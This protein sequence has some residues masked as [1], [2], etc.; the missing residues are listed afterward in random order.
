M[1]ELSR[2][3]GDVNGS[4]IYSALADSL[5]AK[6][7]AVYLSQNHSSAPSGRNATTCDES[8][9]LKKGGLSHSPFHSTTATT[10]AMRPSLRRLTPFTLVALA[11]HVIE[12]GCSNGLKI[13]AV[14]AYFGTPKG[15][16]S[17]GFTPDATCNDKVR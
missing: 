11:G 16:C 3:V 12:L 15:D 17:H 4:A 13:A 2:L 8:Q 6:F 14:E 7:N 1:A 5:V 10:C 9:E